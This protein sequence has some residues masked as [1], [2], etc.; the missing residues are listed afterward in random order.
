MNK[1]HVSKYEWENEIKSTLAAKGV[2]VR[3]REKMEG[4][5]WASFDRDPGDDTAGIGEEEV[6]EV[7]EYLRKHKDEHHIAESKIAI[8]E[9]Q[10]KKY[11]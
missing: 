1:P 9:A 5:L 7:I 2:D 11:L 8:L 10:L 3:D 4:Y 6:E